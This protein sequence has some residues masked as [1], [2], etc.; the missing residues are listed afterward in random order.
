MDKIRFF[1]HFR[2]KKNLSTSSS[3]GFHSGE[4]S[5]R[6]RPVRGRG[7][8]HASLDRAEPDIQSQ[9][10]KSS[11]SRSSATGPGKSSTSSSS[12]EG[13][14]PNIAF[15][16]YLRVIVQVE[17][18][19]QSLNFEPEKSLNAIL[20]PKW[21]SMIRRKWCQNTNSTSVPDS[22]KKAIHLISTPIFMG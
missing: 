11:S 20:R 15:I 8:G 13:L 12:G 5:G 7:R 10:S 21:R 6:P 1:N 4:S 16:S 3:S 18:V 17:T 14:V 22:V 19:Q 2:F 9:P